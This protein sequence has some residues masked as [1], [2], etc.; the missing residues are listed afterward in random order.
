MSTSIMGLYGNG[1]GNVNMNENGINNNLNPNEN[2]FQNRSQ[3]N[4]NPNFMNQN[5]NQQDFNPISQFT[6]QF[7]S[8]PLTNIGLKYGENVWETGK[9]IMDSHFDRSGNALRFYF[10]LDSA[11]VIGKLKRIFYP[12]GSK[13]PLQK[14][15]GLSSSFSAFFFMVCT[16]EGIGVYQGDPLSPLM[17]GYI[18]HFLIEEIKYLVH[19]VQMF[20]DDL[21]LI[22]EGPISEIDKN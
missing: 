7:T 4:Q 1:D 5:N 16:T 3:T 8:N 14:N 6:S 15:I 18:S 12:W 19:H 11:Y 17:F 20:A 2:E 21:I 22:M 13:L 9:H 10:D